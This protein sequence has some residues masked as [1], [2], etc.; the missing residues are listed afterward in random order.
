MELYAEGKKDLAEGLLPYAIG[1]ASMI[2]MAKVAPEFLQAS[3][4]EIK[5][6]KNPMQ[7]MKVKKQFDL[8]VKT[9]KKVPDLFKK[10]ELLQKTFW[11]C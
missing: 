6:I 8:G 10:L 4:D 1:M 2:K 5:S 9:G 7:I 3:V 11:F